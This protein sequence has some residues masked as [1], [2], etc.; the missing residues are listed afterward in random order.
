LSGL[1]R[2]HQSLLPARSDCAAWTTLSKQ[3]RVV[4]ELAGQALTNKAIAAQLFLSPNTVNYHLR[5]VFRKLGI[6]SRVQLAL[7][8]P[9]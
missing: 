2:I 3:E 6:T 8:A 9:H 4:A 1:A 7:R 5:N